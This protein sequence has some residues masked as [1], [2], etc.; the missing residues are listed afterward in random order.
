MKFKQLLLCILTLTTC[1]VFGQNSSSP[2]SQKKELKQNLNDDGSHYVKATFLNQIWLRYNDNNPGSTI[3]GY[4]ENETYDIGLRRIRFQF[5]GQLSDKLFFYTQVG[6]NNISYSSPRKQGLFFHDAVVEF[7]IKKE[8]LSIGSGLTGWGGPSRYSAASIGNLLSLDAP[9]YQQATNDASDQFLRK[10]SLYAKG[11]LGMLDYRLA[12]SKPMSIQQSDMVVPINDNASFSFLPSKMQTSAYFMLQLKDKE[13]NLTPYMKGSYLGTKHILNIGF[14]FLHQNDAM[15]STNTNND[16]V[17]SNLNLLAVDFYYDAPLRS[18][19]G[20]ALTAYASISKNNYGTNY[21]RNIG[22]MNPANGSNNA[23]VI[24][25]GG[26]AF[27]TM[28]TGTTFYTQLGYV[29]PK[30]IIENGKLQ[31]FTALQYSSF[32]R[33]SITMK[34]YEVGFNWYMPN[35]YT[36]ISL[37]LQ[38]RPVFEQNQNNEA[39][40]KMRKSMAVVQ[41]QISI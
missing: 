7:A 35:D 41:I 10:F 25:G 15:W 28:G 39:T 5:Y 27:P 12:L 20:S 36:K 8:K 33:Q 21:M 22:A 29:V 3:F 17:L 31:A 26:S 4:T 19:N 30:S 2:N 24:N 13:S 16:T 9:L 6:Q 14:G 38:N 1:S 37:M 34:M 40:E 11:K 32:D 18:G 23:N